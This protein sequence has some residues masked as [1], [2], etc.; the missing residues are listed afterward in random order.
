MPVPGPRTIFKTL[1]KVQLALKLKRSPLLEYYFYNAETNKSRIIL[2]IS[3]SNLQSYPATDDFFE[4]YSILLHRKYTKEEVAK[5]VEFAANF[6][7]KI[8]STRQDYQMT[9]RNTRKNK[10][11]AAN[12][13]ENK[14]IPKLE[15]V[16]TKREIP[17]FS[18]KTH[19][20]V[21]YVQEIITEAQMPVFINDHS[22]Y[23][24]SAF[25]FKDKNGRV[26]LN[27]Y[28]KSAFRTQRRYYNHRNTRKN[29]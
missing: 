26:S 17:K 11:R 21:R 29:K 2:N 24:I 3:G 19:S 28:G 25:K 23:Y 4:T 10:R 22:A 8:Q 12:F 27:F 20:E 5:G 9:H 15:Q 14:I 18:N 16:Y 7:L 1:G 6:T 13:L